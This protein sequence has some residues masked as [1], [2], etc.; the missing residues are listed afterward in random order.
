MS[1][2]DNANTISSRQPPKTLPVTLQ[3]ATRLLL[4]CH[5]AAFVTPANMELL[6]LGYNEAGEVLKAYV[7]NTITNYLN[8]AITSANYAT[9]ADNAYGAFQNAQL[10]TEE[11]GAF[12]HN[13]VYAK[14]LIFDSIDWMDNGAFNNTITIPAGYPNA[15]AWFGADAAGVVAS[16]P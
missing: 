5:S 1:A 11:K 10:S 12:A 15:R 9:V 16:R 6:R 3:P 14:R 8:V 2:A 7:A 4:K 13:S